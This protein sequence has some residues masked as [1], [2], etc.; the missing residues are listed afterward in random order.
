M[1]TALGLVMSLV[2]ATGLATVL[3]RHPVHQVMVAS[4]HGVALAVLFLL[5]RAPDVALSQIVIGA[6]GF[7]AVAVLTLAK[8][9]RG[10]E[11]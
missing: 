7:P 3:T 1:T 2:A 11:K 10:G 4:V 5:L 9:Q 8:L 6:V